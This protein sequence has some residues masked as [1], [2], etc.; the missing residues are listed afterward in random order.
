VPSNCV[1]QTSDL[2]QNEGMQDGHADNLSQAN[3]LEITREKLRAA[4]LGAF[5]RPTQLVE[6]GLTRDQLPSLVRRGLVTRVSRGLYRFVD[7]EPTENYSLAMACVRVPNSIVCLLSAL[8]VHGIGSQAPAQVW[9][10][11]PHKART[12]RVSGLQLR[13]V[14]FSGPAWTY[15]VRSIELEGVPARITA[16]AR[17]VADC[18]RLE[19]LVG[20]EVAVEALRDA[21]RKR[22]VSIA[23]LVRVEEVLPSRRLR[24]QLEAQSI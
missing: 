5:F 3:G 24:A 14:H 22:I 17:T 12:P 13:I 11:I 4:A 15:G 10:G 1:A 21:L 18:F 6:A 9:L 16:P 2:P 23:E 20:A 8:R 7:A 19:R